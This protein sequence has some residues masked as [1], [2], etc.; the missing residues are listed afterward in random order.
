M[1]LDRNQVRSGVGKYAL[2][3][4]RRYRALPPDKAAEAHDLLGKLEALGIIDTGARGADDEFFVIKLR[5]RSAGAALTA[6]A[7]DADSYDHE[8]AVEVLALASRADHHPNK[9]TPD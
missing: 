2:I 6:Y 4:M 1:K 3:N 9:K 8:W 5:D 7:N